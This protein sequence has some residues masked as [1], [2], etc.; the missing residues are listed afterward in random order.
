ME[1]AWFEFLT[2]QAPVIIVLGLGV[3]AMYKY[4]VAE[5][6]KKDAIIA[7]KDDHIQGQNE[8][9]MHLYKMAI[10]AQTKSIQVQEQ[11]IDLI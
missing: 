1:N 6:T 11:L 4:F 2:K 9:V 7:L 3:Y 8:E 10:E 5:A